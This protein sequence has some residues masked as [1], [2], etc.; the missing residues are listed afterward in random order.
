MA[1]KNAMAKIGIAHLIWKRHLQAG[2]VSCNISL[3]Q[4]YL[5]NQLRDRDYLHPTDIAEILF[6]DRPTASVVIANL[7]KRGWLTR[8]RDPDN[9]RHVRVRIT[10]AGGEM[11][12]EINAVHRGNLQRTIDPLGCFDAAELKQFNGLLDRLLI[13]LA[14]LRG[15]IDQQNGRT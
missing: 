11:L 9:A 4:M 10:A 5:L 7:E 15:E 13:H 6:C 1:T 12:E 8:E 2:L 3:K 14:P